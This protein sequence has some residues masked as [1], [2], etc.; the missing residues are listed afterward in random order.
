[1]ISNANVKTKKSAYIRP[2]DFSFIF[3]E[4]FTMNL[5]ENVKADEC[6]IFVQTVRGC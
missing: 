1:M 5:A 6:N 4:V 3:C 2:N